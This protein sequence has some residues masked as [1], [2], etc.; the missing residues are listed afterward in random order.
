MKYQ[1]LGGRIPRG[2]LLIGQPGTG[3]TLLAKAIASEALKRKT[4][5][6]G[7]RG[8]ME[9]AM[10]DLMFEIP[11]MPNVKECIIDGEVIRKGKKPE[12]VLGRARE[13][14]EGKVANSDE[15]DSA[16]IA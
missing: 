14:Q 7:L 1:N 2:C 10:L 3:K 11:S 16:E 13:E 6:R 15:D 9:T 8:V 4:G 5:A 12:L